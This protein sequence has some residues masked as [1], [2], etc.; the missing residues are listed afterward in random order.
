MTAALLGWM[1]RPLTHR[2]VGLAASSLVG[3]GRL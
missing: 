1:I 2:P 3:P